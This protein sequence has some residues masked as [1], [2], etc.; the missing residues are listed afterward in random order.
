MNIKRFF[1]VKANLT[2]RY[3]QFERKSTRE[4][5]V[6]GRSVK[7]LIEKIQNSDAMLMNQY[8]NPQLR[9]DLFNK[10]NL[11]EIDSILKDYNLLVTKLLI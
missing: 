5:T 8:N 11:L 9:I 6:N 3:K 1:S 2:D 4:V 7:L 10:Q